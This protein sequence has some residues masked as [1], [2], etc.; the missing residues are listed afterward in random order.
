[1]GLKHILVQHK[2]EAE[3]LQRKL[4]AG[5]SF[6]ELAKKYSTCSSAKGGGDLGEVSLDRLVSEFAEAALS[7]NV[8]EISPIVKTRFGHHLILKY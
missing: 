5:E 8:G 3:D 2:Y 6:E 7:L 1:M 4:S